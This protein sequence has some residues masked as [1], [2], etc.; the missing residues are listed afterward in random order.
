[1]DTTTILLLVRM[2]D[3]RTSGGFHG[4]GS[5]HLRCGPAPPGGGAAPATRSLTRL[6]RVDVP[7]TAPSVQSDVD[8]LPDG[9]VI[10]DASGAVRLINQ[11]AAQMLGVSSDSAVGRPLE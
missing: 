1:M 5:V 6:R 7:E 9:V 2:P 4:G 11:R 3:W 10:A 8:L